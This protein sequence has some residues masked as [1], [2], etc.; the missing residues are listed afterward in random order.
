MFN[1]QYYRGCCFCAIQSYPVYISVVDAPFFN[2]YL[3]LYLNVSTCSIRA[4]TL[5]TNQRENIKK[6]KNLKSKKYFF[7]LS[8][9]INLKHLFIYVLYIYILCAFFV[10]CVVLFC[11]PVLTKIW[12]KLLIATQE[13]TNSQNPMHL[14]AFN[15]ISQQGALDITI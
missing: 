2:A 9:S 7:P 15:V 1:G 8:C 11:S 5:G 12:I 14:V 3:T 4:M 13:F 10:I 6:K